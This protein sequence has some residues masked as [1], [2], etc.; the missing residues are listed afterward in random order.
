MSLI[1]VHGRLAY[2]ALLYVAILGGW[3]LWRYFR[4]EGLNANYRGAVTIGTLLVVLQGGLGAFLWLSGIGSLAG[5]SL[6]VLYG[7]VAILLFPG[8]FIYTQGNQDRRAMLIYAL[9]FVFMIGI[10]LRSITTG[11]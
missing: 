3:G 1:E 11:Q 8:A 9:A 6:H 2:T 5:R 4:K 7:V 10:L